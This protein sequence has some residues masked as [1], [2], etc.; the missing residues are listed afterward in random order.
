[1]E[2][3]VTSSSVA[4]ADIAAYWCVYRQRLFRIAYRILHDATAAEDACQQAILKA[5]QM[6]EHVQSV[7]SL[8]GWL[9]R[10]VINE[11]LMILRRR[12]TEKRILANKARDT[13]DA[14]I[15]E[16]ERREAILEAIQRL[17]E[18]ARMVVV[19]RI[20]DGM[21]G[22]QVKEVLGCSAAEV[23]RRLHHGMEILRRELHAWRPV[24]GDI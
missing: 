8:G 9:T 17:P 2:A 1:M 12:K 3:V 20:L 18:P 19:L 21:P 23:S 16:P 4:R 15:E 10:T 14:A 13:V 6:Q 22:S 24:M 7:D 5:C 11:S